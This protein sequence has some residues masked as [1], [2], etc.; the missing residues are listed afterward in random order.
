MG[1]KEKEITQYRVTTAQLVEAWGIS[2][3]AIEKHVK[4]GHI[5]PAMDGEWSW[6]E[7]NH[8]FID[9]F[10]KQA[11][12]TGSAALTDERTRLARHAADKKEF[13][14]GVL[15]KEYVKVNQAEKNVARLIGESKT[16][17]L[18][19][20]SKAAPELYTMIPKGGPST[21]EIKEVIDKHIYES[22]RDLATCDCRGLLLD[23][24]G[25]AHVGAT[26]KAL[27]QR[28]RRSRSVSKRRK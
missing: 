12:G 3:Q 2:R 23:G 9:H 26:T 13:E 18:A 7:I 21:P 25:D 15:R 4:E 17:L 14:L 8:A 27:T 24:A 28:V 16:R 5:P 19:S 20:S 22:L 10:R 1:R 6:P 11:Q